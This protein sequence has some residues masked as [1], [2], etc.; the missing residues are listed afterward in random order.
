MISLFTNS[1]VNTLVGVAG[2]SVVGSLAASIWYPNFYLQVGLAVLA[3]LCLFGLMNANN[4]ANYLLGKIKSFTEDVV[5]G[6]LEGRIT[7]IGPEDELGQIA[8]NFNEALD[9]ME[10]VLREAN[11]FARKV[12]EGDYERKALPEGLRGMFPVTLANINE[13]LDAMT[14][15]MN[16]LE[17]VMGKVGRGD[18]TGRMDPNHDGAI[19][20]TVNGAVERVSGMFDDVGETMQTVA[21]GQFGVRVTAEGEGALND[22][23]NNINSS[24]EAIGAA[25]EETSNV[26]VA[27][28][29]GDMTQRINGNH[30]G[31]LGDLKEALNASLN[32]LQD[33]LANI[34]SNANLVSTGA[35]EISQGSLQLSERTNEQAASLEETAASMNEMASTVEANA[36]N[37]TQAESLVTTS[38]SKAEESVQVVQTAVEAMEQINASSQKIADIITLIDGIAFQTNLLALNASVEAARAGEHGRGF[39]VVAGEVR[40]LAQRAAES[41]KEIRVLIEASNSRVNEGSELV[42]Q[43]G[44]A[45]NE[46]FAS[47]ESVSSLVSEI[48]HASREQANSI[49]QVNEAVTQLDS[50]NQQ[51]AALVEES[52]AASDALNNQAQD[53]R[54]QVSFFKVSGAALGG[55][56]NTYAIEPQASSIPAAPARHQASKAHVAAPVDDDMGEWAEF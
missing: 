29:Q 18:F 51:N 56:S 42:N 25:L 17:D 20:T 7:N 53:L 46:I 35:R 44:E 14:S 12:K 27:M 52:T 43:S 11:A 10:T 38:R 21:Q 3:L 31:R 1:K 55:H 34:L 9:Q 28:S 39:A 30:P 13:S 26:A 36:N 37:A 47:I 15:T 33:T 4:R 41:A 22:L 23:K 54:E 2:L 6:K 19:A 24:L 50:V 5:E 48:S 40:T 45:L 8:W 49:T 32:R 16:S